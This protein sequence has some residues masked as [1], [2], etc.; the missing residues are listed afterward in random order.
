MQLFDDLTI[1]ISSCRTDVGKFEKGN[2]EA[3]RRI[4]KDMQ[5]IKSLA[6]QIR[7]AVL[8]AAHD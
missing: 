2:K 6:Q 8:E 1:V 7:E 3:G 4:R 5:T